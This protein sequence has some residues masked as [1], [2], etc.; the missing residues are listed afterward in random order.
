M[1]RGSQS[2]IIYRRPSH[3]GEEGERICSDGFVQKDIAELATQKP[4]EGCESV[5]SHKESHDASPL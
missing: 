3:G 1:K 2:T 5:K 4:A